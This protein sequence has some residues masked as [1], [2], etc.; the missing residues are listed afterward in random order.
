MKVMAGGTG[1]GRG[2]PAPNAEKLKQPG[3]MAAAL[4]WVTHNTNVDTTVPSM[5]DIDQLEENIKA[6]SEPF[7]AADEK[8]LAAI[9][10]G[11]ALS[12]DGI[13]RQ[14]SWGID[15]KGRLVETTLPRTRY[16]GVYMVRETANEFSAANQ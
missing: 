13:W 14:H 15:W 12:E 6:M 9:V 2:R 10:T 3:A 11:W 5:T 1:T 8:R 7:G 16:F 4:R